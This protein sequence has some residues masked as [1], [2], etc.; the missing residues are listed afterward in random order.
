MLTRSLAAVAVLGALVAGYVA[1]VPSGGDAPA[2]VAASSVPA[3]A[4]ASVL[5][6]SPPAVKP[7]WQ[8]S[9]TAQAQDPAAPDP[10]VTATGPN[11]DFS[12]KLA[13]IDAEREVRANRPIKSH[14]A[15]LAPHPGRPEGELDR[16]PWTDRA[17]PFNAAMFREERSRAQHH[18]GPLPAPERLPG[19]NVMRQILLGQPKK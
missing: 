15:A 19:T 4:S 2:A 16:K 11:V 10:L 17:H 13:A 1:L 5:V 7:Y 14:E 12:A 9:R 6:G 3:P 8:H 18:Q